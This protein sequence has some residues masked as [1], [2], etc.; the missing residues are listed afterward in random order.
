MSKNKKIKSNQFPSDKILG[1]TITLLEN[2]DPK[3]FDIYKEMF[4]KT[5]YALKIGI[6]GSP[7]VGKSTLI[8][9][10][11]DCFM[12]ENKSIATLLIDP[13]NPV[14]G[15]AFLGDRIRMQRHSMDNKVFIRSLANRGYQGGVT[16]TLRP[17][18]HVLDGF[19]FDIILVETV[20]TGQDETE[21]RDIVDITLVLFEPGSGDMIQF[22]KSGLLDIGD[23]LVVNKSDIP[24]SKQ[25]LRDLEMRFH[26][27]PAT[28][29]TPRILSISAKTGEGISSLY[30]A[31]IKCNQDLMK[32]DELE[33]RRKN[34]L[35][36]EI[37]DFLKSHA[38]NDILSFLEKSGNFDSLVKQVM[39]KKSNP[40]TIAEIIYNSWNEKLANHKSGNKKSK[41]KR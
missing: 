9:K 32:S 25:V 36:T 6:T 27:K 8:D 35:V 7:G 2:N 14:H 12:N 34:Q 40:Y 24:Q 29:K 28:E 21:I 15:G 1:E 38:V 31:I 19:G 41:N 22:S 33:N 17:I 16:S 3:G 11:I 18:L 20:G 26:L 4:G 5:G 10:L 13:S 37:R 30:Q 39:D 23:I